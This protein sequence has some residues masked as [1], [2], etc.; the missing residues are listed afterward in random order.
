MTALLYS[1]AN[2]P[3]HRATSHRRDRGV[4]IWTLLAK[5]IAD[6]LWLA[7]IVG[8]LMIGMGAMVGA[9]WPSMRDTFAD[10]SS[11][12]LDGIVQ[13]MPGADLTT[14]IGWVNTELMSIVAPAA[15][16]AVAV[17][18]A[19]RATAGEE[20]AKT[21][22]VVLSAP[23]GRLAFL[24]VKAVA[25][26]IHVVIVGAFLAVGLIVGDLIGNLGLTATGI[27]GATVQTVLLG[28]A[29]GMLALLIGAGTGRR[30]LATASTGALAALAF[31]MNIFLPLS[32]A[33]AAGAKISPWYYFSAGDP[34]LNGAD[35][36]H[37]LVLCAFATIP[38]L[39]AA[40]VFRRRD[41]RG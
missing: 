36:G 35:L 22:G 33:L 29:F 30:R 11:G 14:A 20:E 21:L 8:A 4:M 23:V 10:L 6:R 40:A 9:L 38:A 16:I 34:L 17:I 24:S 13:A 1:R 41:L 19:S 25:V 3:R 37:L 18:S 28:V 5:A 15:A 7:V 39:I 12:L 27:L 2:A 31:A 32:D 26:A